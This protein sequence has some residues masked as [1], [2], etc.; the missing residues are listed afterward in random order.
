M[1]LNLCEVRI[2]E[3]LVAIFSL[4]QANV[5]NIPPNRSNYLDQASSVW[6]YFFSTDNGILAIH[7]LKCTPVKNSII[8]FPFQKLNWN[9]TPA[10]SLSQTR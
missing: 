7:S 3:M 2:E 9:S 4:Q 10:D 5:T 6:N 8:W 1:S